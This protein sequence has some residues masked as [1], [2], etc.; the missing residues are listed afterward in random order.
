MWYL[1]AA[2]SEK[3]ANNK[4]ERDV[5]IGGPRPCCFSDHD[6]ALPKFNQTI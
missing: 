1:N 4:N 2:K 5:D 3:K 6:Y